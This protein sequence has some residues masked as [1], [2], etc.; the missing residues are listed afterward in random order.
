[1]NTTTHQTPSTYAISNQS[2]NTDNHPT[3]HP[4][5]NP[6]ILTRPTS[7][8][9]SPAA[10]DTLKLEEYLKTQFASSVFN[11]R[12]S[13]PKMNTQPAHTH[14]KDN[15]I[16]HT[17]HIRTPVPHHWKNQVKVSLHA[18]YHSYQWEPI[19]YGAAK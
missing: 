4:V 11:R 1:M 17:R 19:K 5:A 13:F 14:L 16:L 9:Y 15:A 10:D 6:N 3:D 12:P 7:L 2:N 8:P 18:E